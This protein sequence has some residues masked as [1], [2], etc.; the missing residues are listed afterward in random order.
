MRVETEKVSVN[1]DYSAGVA[2]ILEN[3]NPL[4][5]MGCLFTTFNEDDKVVSEDLDIHYDSVIIDDRMITNVIEFTKV[6]GVFVRVPQGALSNRYNNQ[7]MIL[8]NDVYL[9]VATGEMIKDRELAFEPDLTNEILDVEDNSFVPKQYKEKLK[10]N[11]YPA[12]SVFEAQTQFK[13]QIY[14]DMASRK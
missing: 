14:K 11:I 12:F 1:I 10:D 2:T 8:S 9:N 6:R 3:Y 4:N 13:E 7:K 5:T